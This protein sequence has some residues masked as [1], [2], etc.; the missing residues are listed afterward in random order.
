MESNVKELT[1]FWLNDI[2]LKILYVSL[3]FEEK[4]IGENE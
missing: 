2:I 3:K 4:V 1:Q